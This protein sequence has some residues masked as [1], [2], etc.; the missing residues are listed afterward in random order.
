MKPLTIAGI[1]LA[2]LGLGY[3][4]LKPS[5]PAAPLT[6]GAKVKVRESDLLVGFRLGGQATCLV[7][8]TAITPANVT[9]R[10]LK[11]TNADGGSLDFATAFPQVFVVFTPDKVLP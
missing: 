3:L 7:E 5:G 1:A 11:T 8:V 4:V 2:G 10:L 9:G 6:V